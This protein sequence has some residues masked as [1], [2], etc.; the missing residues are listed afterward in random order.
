MNLDRNLQARDYDN[1]AAMALA[2]SLLDNA[3]ELI[4]KSIHLNPQSPQARITQAK[5]ELAMHRPAGAIAAMNHHD[6]Y[7]PHQRDAVEPLCLRAQAMMAGKNAFKAQQLLGRVTQD[8]P[9]NA[10]GHRLMVQCLL[11]TSQKIEAAKHLTQVV[12]LDPED[13][14]STRMLAKLVEDANPRQALQLMESLPQDT[15]NPDELLYLARLHQK[16]EQLYEA[17]AI[18]AK[19]VD[20]ELS[21]PNI[22]LEAG[23]L[24][25]EMGEYDQA[26]A[27]LEQITSDQYKFAFEAYSELAVVHMHAGDFAKAGKCWWKASRLNRPAPNALAGLLVCALAIGKP[28]LVMR[29]SDMLDARCNTITRRNLL[30]DL[31]THAACGKTVAKH[32][33]QSVEQEPIIATPLQALLDNATN[34]LAEHAEK[35]PSRADTFYHLANCQQAQN[36]Q[37]QA[38]KTVKNAI[39]INPNY[40]TA[41]RLEERL[42]QIA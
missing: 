41:K 2:A 5:I 27:H 40:A 30:S 31:W 37:E 7:A 42:E 21:D 19:L 32:T 25:D 18:Y 11:S 8:Y 10:D 12:K 33:A 3:F 15:L 16:L 22:Y 28:T 1:R 38:L 20:S 34:V 6:M 23:K 17:H 35:F 24:A 13:I 14:I 26:I 29:V 39:R 36:Q 4:S 9:D